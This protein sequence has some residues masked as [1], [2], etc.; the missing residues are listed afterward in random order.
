MNMITGLYPP[1]SGK[2]IIDNFDLQ[3][4]SKARTSLSLCPQHN[5]LYDELTATEHLL[6]YGTIKGKSTEKELEKEIDELLIKLNLKLKKD[7]ISSAYSGGYKR[8]LNLAIALVGKS[9]IVVL[10]KKN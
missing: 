3:K 9:K 7:I 10:G 6:I 8:K 2:I 4:D 5:I 1:T